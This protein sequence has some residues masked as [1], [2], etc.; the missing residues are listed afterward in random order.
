[1]HAYGS[2]TF[3]TGLLFLIHSWVLRYA[4]KFS[5][6]SGVD[7]DPNLLLLYEKGAFALIQ[8]SKGG[9]FIKMSFTKGFT[10]VAPKTTGQEM[11]AR[12][13]IK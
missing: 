9:V 10:Y 1:M 6:G 5:Q 4:I 2:V 11:M 7:K 12:M 3:M 8:L 13:P